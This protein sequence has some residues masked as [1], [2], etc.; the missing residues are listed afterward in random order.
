[1]FNKIRIAFIIACL[2][3]CAGLG[4]HYLLNKEN[5]ILVE[6]PLSITIPDG[7]IQTDDFG[8]RLLQTVLEQKPG[9]SC[10]VCPYLISDALL[11]LRELADAP[12]QQDIDKLGI[13]ENE[14]EHTVFP[15][16]VVTV[17]ADYGVNFINENSRDVI[18]KLPFRSNLPSAMSIFNGSLGLIDDE[19]SG[20]VVGSNFLSRNTKFIVGLHAD[21]TPKLQT[22]FLAANSTITEFENANGSLPKVC[23]MRTRAN[24]RYAKAHDGDWEAIA[25]L[26]Q[27][28]PQSTGIPTAFVAILPTLSA[29]KTV[30]NL[31]AEKLGEI[32]K[33]LAETA[34]TDC[35]VELPQMRCSFPT[36]DIK[37]LLSRMG[38]A[39][40]F[41]ITGKHWTFTDRNMGIDVIPEKIG[42]TLTHTQGSKEQQADVDNAATKI[43][44]NRPFIWFIGDLT[45]A[46][47]AYY[48]G[49]VQNL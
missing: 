15:N 23:M 1:M 26:L 18:I 42:I 22:P 43:S 47:P 6:R 4:S 30:T 46:T 25:M 37:T 3:I 8:L 32:R 27:P 16:M 41:D 40:L 28:T 19:T 35:C 20:V 21:F 44:F 2:G 29:E 10:L 33:A 13:K 12:I 9:T 39:K 24:V 14:T 38:L 34:P 31:T 45:T 36:H 48:I 11:T 49:L 5:G 17:A 7:G